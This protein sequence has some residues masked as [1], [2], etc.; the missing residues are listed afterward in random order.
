LKEDGVNG[1]QK[2]VLF[3]VLLS[4]FSFFILSAFLQ[5]GQNGSSLAAPYL[6]PT[7]SVTPEP[8]Y[9]IT[10]EVTP[11]ASEVAVGEQLSVTV[12]LVNLSTECIFAGYDMTLSEVGDAVPYFSFDSPQIVG[13]PLTDSTIFTLTAVTSGT[14]QLLARAYG[15]KYCNDYWIWRYESGISA[16][17]FIGIIPYKQYIPFVK[18]D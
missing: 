3:I 13:P 16:P 4:G 2:R 17:I 10:V 12:N 5:V 8:Y 1:M 11:S 6:T 18:I 15:E 14:V 7:P 9:E